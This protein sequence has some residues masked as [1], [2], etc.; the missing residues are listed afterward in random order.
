MRTIVNDW[1][2]KMGVAENAAEYVSNAIFILMIILS[3]YISDII[4]K[5]ILVKGLGIDVKKIHD[6]LG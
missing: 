1:I 6:T 4:A 5:R 2:I 3:I